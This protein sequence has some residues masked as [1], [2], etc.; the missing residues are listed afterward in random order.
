L[1][2]TEVVPV[3]DSRSLTLSWPITVPSSAA[4]EA[5]KR[6]KPDLVLSHLIGKL[7]HD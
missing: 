6:H 7:S 4:R 5:L 2:V 1:Q 3:A